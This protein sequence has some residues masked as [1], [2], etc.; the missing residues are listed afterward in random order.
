MTGIIRRMDHFEVRLTDQDKKMVEIAGDVKMTNLK[1]EHL[2]K[3]IDTTTASIKEMAASVLK[4]NDTMNRWKGMFFIVMGAMP[5]VG[6][7]VA[8]F[9]RVWLYGVPPTK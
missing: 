9:V 5:V 4:A 8:I 7:L 2:T 3:Q 1:I 6:P